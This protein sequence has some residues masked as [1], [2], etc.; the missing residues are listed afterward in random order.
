[1]FYFSDLL[2]LLP[3]SNND[4]VQGVGNYGD[5]DVTLV[6]E[7]VL[8]FYTLRTFTLQV[9]TSPTGKKKKVS[10]RVSVGCLFGVELIQLG[11]I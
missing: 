2:L 3:F 1:M 8:A 10:S 6:R 5:I 11:L 4:M 7:D 9:V